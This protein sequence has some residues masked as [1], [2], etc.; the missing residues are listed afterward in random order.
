[1]LCTQEHYDAIA[2]FEKTYIGRNDKEPKELWKIGQIFQDGERNKQFQMFFSG[3]MLG[4][5]TY[6]NQ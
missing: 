4:R 3:Y 6:M 1:M 5:A 2:F